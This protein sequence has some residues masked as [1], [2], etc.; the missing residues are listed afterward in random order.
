MIM[1]K[2]VRCSLLIEQ[3][4]AQNMNSYSDGNFT[5]QCLIDVD[6]EEI[7]P[8]IMNEFE[9]ISLLRWMMMT[10]MHER[11]SSHSIFPN[12]DSIAGDVV[13]CV[14]SRCGISQ[15]KQRTFQ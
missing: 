8:K 1:I 7:C 3:R 14:M 15:R 4:I 2:V 9:K 11:V 5:K 10:M 13:I 12:I 6:A